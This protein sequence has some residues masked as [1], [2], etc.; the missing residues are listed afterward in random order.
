M[1]TPEVKIEKRF[2]KKSIIV[3]FGHRSFVIDYPNTESG[4]LLQY[5]KLIENIFIDIQNEAIEAAIKKV[6]PLNKTSQM[7]K[8]HCNDI[9]NNIRKLKK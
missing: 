2:S 9:K 8:V 4:E 6:H 3:H 7:D 1:K 5:S